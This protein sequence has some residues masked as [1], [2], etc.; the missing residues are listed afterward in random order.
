MFEEDADMAVTNT[1]ALAANGQIKS[2]KL[3]NITVDGHE[4]QVG[5]DQTLLEGL[6][7]AGIK[8]PTLC[9]WQGLHPAGAC[10]VCVVELEG[11]R[12][13]VASCTQPIVDGMV[14]R[15]QTPRVRLARKINLELQLANH[16][17]DCFYCQR[18]NNC[19][20]QTLAAE[21]GVERRYRGKRKQALNDVTSYALMRDP[22]K[23]ILCQR[24]VTTCA[25]VQAV[26]C[27]TPLK[28][29]FDTT[30]GVAFGEGIGDSECVNCGQCTKVCPTGA[31]VERDDLAKVYTALAD[32]TKY[33]VA[34]IAPA[35]RVSLAQ[36][37]GMS[38]GADFTGKLVAGLKLVG[39]T[40]V[41]D[42]NYAAD[43]TIMEEAAE[44]VG[45]V[46]NNG[47]FPLVTSCCPAWIKFA[48]QYYPDHLENLSSCKSPQMMMGAV[49]HSE[50]AKKTE[51]TRDGTF[52][53]SM[54]PC[55]AKK[56][57]MN[58]VSEGDVDVVLTTRELVRMLKREQINLAELEPVSFDPV[59]GA[60][61]GAAAIFG[62]SGGVAEAAIRTAY[63]M[64]TG[65]ELPVPDFT[66][67]RG[68]EGVKTTVVDVNGVQLRSAVISGLQ[69]VRDF[70]AQGGW[71]DYHFIE[72]MAC[73]GGC[74]NGGGQ[75]YS[76]HW[77][78]RRLMESLYGIDKNMSWR[79]SH[80]NP[81]IVDLYEQYLGA[82]NS[83]KAHHLLHRSYVDRS[84]DYLPQ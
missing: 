58:K 46:K 3:V 40:K 22:E 74:I 66:P 17:E 16:P 63:Q 7:E 76:E 73:P 59:F 65:E 32:P 37:F 25:D 41:F 15:T 64:V 20:L 79:R 24:C 67:V 72:V 26:A 13:L 36:E 45:R 54:M 29:G 83:E 28:R 33:V 81:E 47:P 68:L 78:L 84:M 69:N 57:E 82:P 18:N 80:E 14:V 23:C 49:L 12:T 35:V 50:Y 21:Y 44:L 53:V 6:R 52:V 61:T 2:R 42:T 70:F 27:I 9:N 62:V 19:E 31:L 1:A 60:S 5:A 30:I 38:P 43:L 34:Q 55:T 10:R 11:A 56:W 77:P 51:A 75:P 39:F 48:E 4:Y 71:E 8:V